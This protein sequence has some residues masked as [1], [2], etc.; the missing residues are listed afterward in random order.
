MGRFLRLLMM[1]G[2][3]IYKGVNKLIAARKKE[4]ENPP[5]NEEDIADEQ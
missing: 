5:T 1:F 2:P 4:N 3:M